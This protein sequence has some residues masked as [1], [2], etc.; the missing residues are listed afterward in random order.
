MVFIQSVQ[1][2]RPPRERMVWKKSGSYR[3]N[4][5]Y[6]ST[7]TRGFFVFFAKLL[8]SFTEEFAAISDLSWFIASF[9]NLKDSHFI[10][11]QQ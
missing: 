10:P 11:E 4:N 7:I 1:N 2:R 6:Q 5:S 9:K 8:V 3:Y